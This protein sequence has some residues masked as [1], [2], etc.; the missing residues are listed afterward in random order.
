M[1][2]TIIGLLALVTLGLTACGG[3]SDEKT[4]TAKAKKETLF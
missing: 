3:G 4:D 2:K 1:K